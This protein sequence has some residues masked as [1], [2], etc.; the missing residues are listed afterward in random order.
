[1]GRDAT[2]RPLYES[3]KRQAKRKFA[4]WPSARASQ[5]LVAEYRRRGGRFSGST[6]GGLGRWQRE[7]WRN[8]CHPSLPPCGGKGTQVCRPSV[9]VSSKTPMPLAHRVSPAQRRRLCSAKRRN[10]RARLSFTR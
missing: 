4:A 1:M 7:A 6:S 8:L 9:R 5:W 10:P 3:V 2:N